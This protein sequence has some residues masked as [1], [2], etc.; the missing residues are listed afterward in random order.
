ML[1]YTA[2]CLPVRSIRHVSVIRRTYI[3]CVSRVLYMLLLLFLHSASCIHLW[4]F[5]ESLPL[6]TLRQHTEQEKMI[7]KHVQAKTAAIALLCET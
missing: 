6:Q 7:A 2:P 4:Q 5:R 1:T 3:T